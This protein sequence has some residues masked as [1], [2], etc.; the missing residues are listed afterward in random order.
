MKTWEQFMESKDTNKLTCLMDIAK[1][2]QKV[3][4]KYAKPTRE[5]AWKKLTSEKGDKMVQGLIKTPDKSLSP[6]RTLISP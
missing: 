3:F 6:F 1:E 4:K 2:L 5:D